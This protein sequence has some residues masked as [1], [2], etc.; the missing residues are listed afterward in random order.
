MRRYD[1]S[2]VEEREY[3]EALG[4]KNQDVDALYHRTELV[5]IWRKKSR[6]DSLLS[7]VGPLPQHPPHPQHSWRVVRC[8]LLS[9]LVQ[10]TGVAGMD[11]PGF[12]C[13]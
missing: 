8:H 2:D 10:A 6:A 7:I 1:Y 9:T 5:G 4:D 12:R 3:I 13:R 11:G